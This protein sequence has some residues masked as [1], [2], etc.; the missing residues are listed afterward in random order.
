MSNDHQPTMVWIDARLDSNGNT[1]S[2]H[3]RRQTPALTPE[4]K[5][6]KALDELVEQAKEEQ[7][8]EGLL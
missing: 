5:R 1:V 3:W 4:Q 7:R 6:Q 8:R 2:G